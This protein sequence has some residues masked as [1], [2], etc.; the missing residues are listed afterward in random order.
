MGLVGFYDF[1]KRYVE[2]YSMHTII[3]RSSLN[4]F[5]PST[6]DLVFCVLT[7]IKIS[8]KTADSLLKMKLFRN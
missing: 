8:P 5:G 4:C 3:L 7:A 6:F 1:G 2:D